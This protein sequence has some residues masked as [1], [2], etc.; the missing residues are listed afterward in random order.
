MAARSGGIPAWAVCPSA[1]T[2]KAPWLMVCRSQDFG[3]RRQRLR[4]CEVAFI[5][6]AT[7]LVTPVSQRYTRLRNDG[8]RSKS[9]RVAREQFHIGPAGR[10]TG[11]AARVSVIFPPRLVIRPRAP[12]RQRLKASGFRTAV[13]IMGYP[14]PP[15]RR[16]AAESQR[17]TLIDR[18]AQ[19]VI[20]TME[21]A[22]LQ[23]ESSCPIC[24]M[25]SAR[26]S[27]VR[28]QTFRVLSLD[29]PLIVRRFRDNISSPG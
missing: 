16:D 14:Y 8:K 28:E 4:R 9:L 26:S 11:S 17:L 2:R 18:M 6:P 20:K 19:R 24:N 5:D 22:A 12:L 21:R 23:R 10:R 3:C 13:H 7:L 25:Q 15:L 29:G 27:H 1:C